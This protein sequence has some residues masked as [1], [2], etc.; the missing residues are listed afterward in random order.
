MLDVIVFGSASVDCFVDTGSRIF[1]PNKQ[2]IKFPFGSKILIEKLQFFTGGGGTNV[3]VGLSRLR[4][5]SSFIGKV[6]YGYNSE[7]IME[8][9]KNEKVDI[10]R[11]IRCDGKTGFSV[12]LDAKGHDRTIL[13]FKGS[14]NDIKKEDIDLKRLNSKWVYA[15]TML[16]GSFNTLKYVVRQC[17]KNN[18]RLMFNPSEYMAKKG[19]G[20]LKPILQNSEVLTLNKEESFLLSKKKNIIESLSR[21][22]SFG[23]NIVIITDGP[24]KLHCSNG[25]NLYTLIPN[26]IKVIEATGAGDAFGSGFLAGYIKGGVELGLKIGLVNSQSVIRHFG[27]KNKLLKWNE[28]LE[29]SKRIKVLKKHL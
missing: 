23:P 20:F 12:V 9:L 28:A 5:K 21:L 6:G 24:N 16:G 13:V 19:Y 8:E 18:I 4:L 2:Y 26:K 27:S 29:K 25:N 1:H 22:R 10:S 14:N 7:M 3:A 11:V 15:G 17:K